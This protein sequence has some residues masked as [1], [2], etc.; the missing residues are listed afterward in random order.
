MK[1]SDSIK[2][3]ISFRP[4]NTVVKRY[5]G[6]GN[7]ILFENEIKILRFLEEKG[8][9]FVPKIISVDSEKLMFVMDNCGVRARNLTKEI[10]DQL[11]LDLEKK[12]GVKHNDADP[13]NVVYNIINNRFY[14]IDFELSTIID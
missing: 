8:C 12:Y 4:D 1:L 7:R 10:Q 2:S 13:R 11:F 14:I 9:D 5:I 6:E 3:I